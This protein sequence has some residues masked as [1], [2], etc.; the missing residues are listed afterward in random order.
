MKNKNVRLVALLTIFAFFACVLHAVMLNTPFNYYLYTSVFKIILFVFCPVFYFK[1]CRVCGN[2]KTG[3]IE[4][5][6]KIGK[7]SD[8]F[9]IKGDKRNIKISFML[10]F[11]VFA[12]IIIAFMIVRPFIDG[13]MIIAAL[14]A[15]GITAGNFPFVFIYIVLIN[16]ALEEIFFRG[17]VFMT[18]HRM[19][20]K[21]Y[22][23]IYSSLLFAFYHI[24]VLDNALGLGMLIFCITGLVA[25]GLIFNAL[26]IKCRSMTGSV[27]VHISANLAL[28]L[29]VV[30]YL[31]TV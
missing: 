13:E 2:E 4:Q 22:A 23:H 1:V 31:V 3:K 15:N 8:M 19:N 5:T 30:Y 12:F 11:G 26:I 21:K 14:A 7:F 16:A 18:L 29:I 9:R 28:N 27:V 10:S 25:A 17:F 24:A 20:F 6:E